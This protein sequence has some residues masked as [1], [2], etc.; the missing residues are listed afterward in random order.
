LLI[1]FVVLAVL[2]FGYFAGRWIVET[3]TPL[4]P[5]SGRLVEIFKTNAP[6]VAEQ[7]VP[8]VVVENFVCGKFSSR[9]LDD[10]VATSIPFFWKQEKRMEA[11]NQVWRFERWD[12]SGY[13]TLRIVM[14]AAGGADLC[15]ASIRKG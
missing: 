6:S 1:S 7:R 9:E 12:L 14:D 3:T 5:A 10:A 8:V 11:D 2:L 4:S 15:Q 13:L